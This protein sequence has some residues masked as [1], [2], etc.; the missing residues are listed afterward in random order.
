MLGVHKS[1]RG[2]GAKHPAS[3]GALYRHP[4]SCQILYLSE[5]SKSWPSFQYQ[6]LFLFPFVALK[7][8]AIPFASGLMAIP[9]Q[10]VQ[11]LTR[12]RSQSTLRRA[13]E[14]RWLST[15]VHCVIL[16]AWLPWN[17]WVVH[18]A[19]YKPKLFYYRLQ[20]GR[21]LVSI[22]QIHVCPSI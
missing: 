15:L 20:Q 14:F 4:L 2:L 7:A 13:V 11:A 10:C 3:L 18:R 9:L 17:S 12:V 21:V 8:L 22:L 6:E 1:L 19:K 16:R 5:P